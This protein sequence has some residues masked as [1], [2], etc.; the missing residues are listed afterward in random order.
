MIQ[1]TNDF[2]KFNMHCFNYF[3]PLLLLG[4]SA[5]SNSFRKRISSNFDIKWL[6]YQKTE[7]S[8]GGKVVF[9]LFRRRIGS[10]VASQ[11]RMGDHHESI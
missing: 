1:G 2:S 10:L 8:A 6:S 11:L 7:L 4:G 9:A 3:S 5:Q